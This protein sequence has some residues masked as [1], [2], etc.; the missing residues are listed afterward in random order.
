MGIEMDRSKYGERRTRQPSNVFSM[1]TPTQITS[2]KEVFN[3]I[4]NPQD[5]KIDENDLKNFL[6]SIINPEQMHEFQNIESDIS[7]YAVLSLLS[8]KFLGLRPR[9]PIIRSLM[10]FS[11]DNMTIDRSELS[12]HLIQTGMTKDDVSYIFKV[13]GEQNKLDINDVADLLRHG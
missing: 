9:E 2:L 1:L 3:M 4:D 11:D 8:D 6:P 13:F 12:A 5:E 10:E 7:F